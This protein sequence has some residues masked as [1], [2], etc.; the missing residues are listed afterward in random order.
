MRPLKITHTLNS[1]KRLVVQ[2]KRR[3]FYVAWLIKNT[4]KYIF[5]TCKVK[6]AF[7]FRENCS[8]KEMIKASKVN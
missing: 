8:K 4:S 3:F 2:F 1:Q 7:F 5:K 6:I